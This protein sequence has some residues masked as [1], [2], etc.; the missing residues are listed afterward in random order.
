M[1]LT[2]VFD[3]NYLRS[4]GC[5]DF[6]SGRLPAR[7]A[8]QVNCAIQRGDLILLP[9]TVRIET[10]A[11]LQEENA[12]RHSALISAVKTL[13]QAGF[14]VSPE[15]PESPLGVDIMRILKETDRSCAVL[16]PTIDDYREAERRTSYRLPP[17]PKNIEHEEMRDRL[18]WCE[19]LRYSQTTKNHI[20]IV[21][22]DH[23]FKNGVATDEGVAARITVAASQEDLDQR[24]G[25]RPTHIQ[26]IIDNLLLFSAQLQEHG[27]DISGTNIESVD[28]VRN[29]RTTD[30]RV[31]QRF[32]IFLK[33]MERPIKAAMSLVASKPI[34][35]TFDGKNV[36]L[37]R[38]E[39]VTNNS[40]FLQYFIRE[41]P[42]LSL[43]ELRHIIGD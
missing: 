7:L 34:F 29:V 19:L 27:Y 36:A 32:D 42:D 37:V 8:H 17:H 35:L 2:I 21:S 24:L 31:E 16:E 38:T 13:Q 3:T 18:I 26:T 28:Q 6:L 39:A 43:T 22:N 41:H 40:E 11:W 10:N 23:I 14:N 4:L 12:K 25:E 30:G 20:L 5:S 15:I 1:P 9:E 33:G